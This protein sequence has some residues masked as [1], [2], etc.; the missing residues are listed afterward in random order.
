MTKQISMEPG[1]LNMKS[2]SKTGEQRVRMRGTTRWRVLRRQVSR[3]MSKCTRW[4]ETEWLERVR[5]R[6]PTG[7]KERVFTRQGRESKEVLPLRSVRWR[8]RLEGW[9][10]RRRCPGGS[11]FASGN[12]RW[13]HARL[14]AEPTAAKGSS[15][16]RTVSPWSPSESPGVDGG[17]ESGRGGVG[18]K[19]GR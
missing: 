12:S 18:Q 3:Q 2:D 19:E 6:I 11:A 13:N 10:R 9:G 16:R 14:S 17:F 7:G 15:S 1:K 5:K 4:R 8:E